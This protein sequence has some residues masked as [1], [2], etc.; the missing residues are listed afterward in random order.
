MELSI[1]KHWIYQIEISKYRWLF[2][3]NLFV[4]YIFIGSNGH[5]IPDICF[6]LFHYLTFHLLTGSRSKICFVEIFNKKIYLK[7]D[8]ALLNRK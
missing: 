2:R 4:F 5:L 7:K 8:K 1:G 3:I 6:T